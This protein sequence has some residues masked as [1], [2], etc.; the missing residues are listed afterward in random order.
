MRE[1]VK[2]QKDGCAEL[3]LERHKNY[4]MTK[5]YGSSLAIFEEETFQKYLRKLDTEFRDNDHG[6]SVIRYFLSAAV[7]MMTES[8]GKW[9]IPQELLTC[10][11][12]EDEPLECWQCS[13]EGEYRD[14][15]PILLLAARS[16][17]DNAIAMTAERHQCNK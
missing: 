12:R 5:W 13:Y 6:R 16:N 10:I 17:M 14:S 15:L 1:P 2:L 4:I 11:Y 3:K 8:E 9:Q 7:T